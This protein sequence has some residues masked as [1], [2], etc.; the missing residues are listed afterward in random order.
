MEGRVKEDR[1]I[2]THLADVIFENSPMVVGS[3]L[4]AI[5]KLGIEDSLSSFSGSVLLL[6]RRSDR[7]E[8]AN[9]GIYESRGERRFDLFDERMSEN[10]TPND[11]H[12]YPSSPARLA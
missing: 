12:D 5:R 8:T 1:K 7:L 11:H 10:N 9:C 4:P 3:G 6:I 2:N